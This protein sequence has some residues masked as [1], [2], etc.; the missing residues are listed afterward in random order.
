MPTRSLCFALGLFALAL[1]R[2]DAA[3]A[4]NVLLI[5]I[6]DLNDWVG[7]LGGH[8]QV[9]TPAIDA[10]AKRGTT[11]TN[12]HCQ[13]PLCNPS[14][15]SF[16][17]SRR[18]SSTGVY[19]LNPHFRHAEHLE[20][21]T[22]VF[23]HFRQH[24]Y[25]TYCVGKIFHSVWPIRRAKQAKFEV[26]HLGDGQSAEPMMSP[27]LSGTHPNDGKIV[28][29]GV[30][31]DMR[32]RCDWKSADWTIDKLASHDARS[33][34]PFFMACGFYL[35]HVPIY[36]TQKWHDLYP[37]STLQLPPIL[38]GDRDDCSPFAWYFTW[39]D[40][41]PKTDWLRENEQLV[42]LVRSYLAA[43]SFT[44]SQVARV[45]TALEDSGHV[46]D[47]IIVLFSDH[48]FH[49]G[50]K[51]VSGKHTL[52]EESTRVPLIVAGPDVP[53]GQRCAE[54]VELLDI[55][56]TLTDLTGLPTPDEVEGLSLGAQ[57]DDASTPRERP[58]ICTNSPNSHSVRDERWRFIQ[59]ADG[60]RELYDCV[61]DP[62]EH[63]NLIDEPGHESVIESI[64]QWL[65]ELNVDPV[66]GSR[67]K[68]V[69]NRDGR[70]YYEDTLI[71]D[72]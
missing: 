8:A 65:P 28:D 10:L 46:D 69:S 1:P 44:D 19:A 53:K 47:T 51:G 30:V 60:S 23:Q 71:Q 12:A 50:E 17:L 66:P 6:D 5:A 29:W 9:Q 22:T 61:A 35:P 67:S 62:N 58:A 27:K 36:T 15:T 59:Y 52:W 18:P 41:Y 39:T 33:E 40:P 68:M 11:F 20:D 55:Y 21:A 70:W 34:K 26:D 63:T 45:L 64:A 56:P 72:E 16:L 43:V 4:P 7:P 24:G 57:L 37:L 54:A 2:A 25:E 14:R 32:Q 31:E 48:G 42:P 38:D 3:E 49:C 13:S